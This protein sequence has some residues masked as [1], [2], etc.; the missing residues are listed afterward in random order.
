[1]AFFSYFKVT[2]REASMVRLAR[3]KIAQLQHGYTKTSGID[4]TK[5]ILENSLFE[6]S[7]SQMLLS[8]ILYFCQVVEMTV[9]IALSRIHNNLNV[10]ENRLL[11]LPN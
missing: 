2:E 10:S 6:V 9:R 1:M 8:E 7:S 4:I 3:F 5:F 11:I